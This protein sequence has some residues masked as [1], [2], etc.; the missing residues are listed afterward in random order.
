MPREFCVDCYYN[1]PRAPTAP[2][3]YSLS[4]VQ[5]IF[6]LPQTVIICVVQERFGCGH[7]A[8]Q[9]ILRTCN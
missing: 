4:S 3:Q 8:H 2:E 6:V 5:E 1:E 7:I 9:I